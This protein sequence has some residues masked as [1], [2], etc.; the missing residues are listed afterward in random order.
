MHAKELGNEVP[1]SP[2]FFMKPD[3]SL[4]VKNRP[5][6]Y[7]EFSKEIQYETELVVHINKVGKNIE[8]KFAHTYYDKVT[9]GIDFTARDIQREAKVKGLPWEKAK[10]FD[11]SAVLAKWVAK[12]NFKDIQDISFYLDIN[13]KR[14]QNGN[15]GMMTFSIDYLISYI[16]KYMTLKIG[17]ILY[18]GTPAG[19]GDVAVGDQLQGYLEDE[20]MFD[21]KVK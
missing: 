8:E 13:G 11:N 1:F 15:S 18:T 12:E 16:S 7:P 9:L 2:V 20:K 14:V 21:F 19:V 6:Y 3:T 5:F 4:L 10:A 17:D